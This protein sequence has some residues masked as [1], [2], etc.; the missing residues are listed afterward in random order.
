VENIAA[1]PA[2]T[3]QFHKNIQ[4]VICHDGVEKIGEDS[5]YSCPSLRRV[6]MPGVKEVERGAFS[7]CEA[8]TYIE[9]GKLERIGE[10]AFYFCTSLS[11]ID[12]PSIKIAESYAFYPC[13]NLIDVKFGKDLESIRRWAFMCCYSLERITLPLKDGI[14]ADNDNIFGGCKKL[15]HIDLVEEVHET[16]AALLLE[17][18]KNDMNEEIDAINQILPKTPPGGYRDAGEKT[19]A[20]QTWIRS[21][22]RK[23]THYKAEHCRYVNEAAATLQSSLPND[24]VLKNVLPFLQ[25]PSDTCEAD[26]DDSE[27]DNIPLAALR[28]T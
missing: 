21:V 16:A 3:F 9:C 20:I 12:L 6:I 11:S 26:D 24:V 18:W 5:F 7:W 27:D 25:L 15:N 14:I 8:L 22:L 17:E 1:V 19:Q 2:R 4:V 23:Y 13:G 28:L 10:E